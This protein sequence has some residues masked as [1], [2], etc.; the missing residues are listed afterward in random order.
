MKVGGNYWHN[1]FPGLAIFAMG[2]GFTFVAGTLAA[3]SGVPKHFSGLASGVLNTSQQVGGA[4][5]LG[6][7]SAVAF[8]TLK[9]DVVS[10][11][12][13]LSA[14]VHGYRSGIHV[15]VGLALAAAVVVFFVVKNNKVDAKEAL[16]AG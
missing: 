12:S 5:G 4:I 8:S 2:M 14:Q 1:V 6:I 10:G 3:T 16:L 11:V 9:K 7:L 15:G 13:P